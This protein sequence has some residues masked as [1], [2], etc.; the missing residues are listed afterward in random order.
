[1]RTRFLPLIMLLVLSL[2]VRAAETNPYTVPTFECL[3]L[4]FKVDSENPGECAVRYRAGGESRWRERMPLWF[5]SRNREFRGSLV[6]L[7]PGTEYEI[8]LTVGG[9]ETAFSAATRPDSF[10]VGKVT[11]L[12]NGVT[13]RTLVVTESGSPGAWH[14]IV[15]AGEGKTVID[16]EKVVEFNVVIDADYVVLRGLALKGAEKDA[17]RIRKGRHDI[18]IE[19]CHITN[20]GRGDRRVAWLG[21]GDSGINAEEGTAGLVIQRNRIDHPT[22]WTN[23]WDTGHPAGPQGITLWN[24]R[25]GNI[26]R[27]NEIVTTEEHGFNDAIGGGSNYSFEGSPNRDSDIYGNLIE[28]VWDD[29]IESEGAN[30]NVRIW[31]NYIARTYTHIATASTSYGPLYIF[32]NVFGES[33]RTRKDPTGGPM[34]KMGERDPYIGGR[35]WVFHNTALQPRGAFSAFSTHPPTNTVS[36]NNIFDCP[37]PLTYLRRG[38]PPADLDH[39]LFTGIDMGQGFQRNAIRTRPAY[40]PSTGLEFFLAPTTTMIRWGRTEV[41]IEGRTWQITDK[42]VEIDNPAIDAGVRLPGFNDDFSGKGPDLG[43]FERGRPPLVFGRQGMR[44][45]YLAPWER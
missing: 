35:R 12:D 45:G 30:M 43:A 17:I 20:W 25:G 22:G 15:P 26:I 7:N 40:V 11:Y 38:D 44:P 34:I 10:P 18:V 14:L 2:P 23:D 21:W 3:G 41:T 6:G 33:R 24:S 5:D 36:R 1:M 4:Y 32:R 28:G 8:V 9:R 42:M 13:D 31:G 39:D 19:D 37:G 16:G 27:Y 29:A